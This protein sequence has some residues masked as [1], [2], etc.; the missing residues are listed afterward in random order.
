MNM[1]L[2]TDDEPDILAISKTFL[3][4]ASY[5]VVT[6]SDGDEAI[7]K[8]EAEIP[9]LILQDVV[10]PGKS[11]FEVCRT[12]KTNSKTRH[13]PVIMFT[14]LGRDVDMRL[15]E[16]AGADGHFM[17]PFTREGLLSMVEGHLD[18]IR[19]GKFSTQLGLE[20]SDLKGKKILFEFDPA[21]QYGRFIR[22]FT[23]ECVSHSERM[24]VVSKKGSVTRQALD[25]DEGVEFLEL[26]LQTRVFSV[27]KDDQNHPFAVVIDSLTDLALTTDFQTAYNFARHGLEQLIDLDVK[28]LFLLNPAAHETREVYSFRGLFTSQVMYGCEGIEHVR[29]H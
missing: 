1:I 16:E 14:A 15:G 5:K 11:G 13:I 12:L 21:A 28:A 24:I 19:K 20:H 23:L 29:I 18:R 27:I 8:A 6:A 10:M 3:E 4:N 2:V 7:N 25:G 22:D 26:G 17:K 9:D